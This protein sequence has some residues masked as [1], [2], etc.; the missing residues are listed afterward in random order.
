[1]HMQVPLASSYTHHT[2]KRSKNPSQEQEQLLV[3]I[4]ATGSY[5]KVGRRFESKKAA[6]LM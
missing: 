2:H 1:M 6:E 5:M 4:T 3:Y